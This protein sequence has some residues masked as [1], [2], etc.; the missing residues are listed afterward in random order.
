[1]YWTII[2]KLFRQL[3]FFGKPKIVHLV[4]CFVKFVA[5]FITRATKCVKFDVLLAC[6]ITLAHFVNTW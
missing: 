6:F 1:M 2:K 4:A 5:S 3:F